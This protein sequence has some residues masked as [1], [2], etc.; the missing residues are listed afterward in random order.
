MI[1]LIIVISLIGQAWTAAE[2]RV[3][4]SMLPRG[5][6]VAVMSFLPPSHGISGTE[7]FSLY[8][9]ALERHRPAKFSPAYPKSQPSQS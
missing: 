7:L 9:L 1:G 4:V 3:I 2:Q 8:A 6:A 5:V